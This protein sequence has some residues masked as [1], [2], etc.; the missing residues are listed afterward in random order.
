M[1]KDVK[2]ADCN[3]ARLQTFNLDAVAPLVFILEEAQ[4]GT[5]T[6]QSAAE[7]AKAAL[8]LLGNAS[9]QTAKERR[10]KVTKDL[11]KDLMSLAEDPEMF[12]DAAPL[13]F[14]A[15]FE[16]KMKEHLESLKCLRQSMTPKNGYRSDQFFRGSR[17]QYPPRGG[18]SN[19]RARGGQRF[20][21]YPIK[22]A[23]KSSTSGPSVLPQVTT[24]TA[25]N[26]RAVRSGL[27][28]PTYPLH[29]GARKSCNG[30]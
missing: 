18:G 9:A 11:N 8:L 5:L 6:S 25:E 20:Q 28:C 7:A 10:K 19:Y 1:S 22:E 23:E 2:D 14:G 12:E 3:A 27:L 30:G 17:P 16:R 26:V 13:L 29:R 15:S 24:G 21:P 4:K